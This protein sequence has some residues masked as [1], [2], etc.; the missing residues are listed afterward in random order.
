MGDAYI[1]DAVRTPRGKGR[2]S[3]S[4][5]TVRP[6][7]LLATALRALRDRNGLDTTQVDDVVAGCVTQTADQGG[8]IA[9]YAALTAGYDLD[10]AGLTLNRFCGSGLEAINH[11]GAMV[12][13]GYADLIVAGGVESMSRVKMGSDGGAVWDP[14]VQ[15]QIGSVPQGVSADLLAML[16]GITREQVD[17][18]ALRSQQRATAARE[19]GHFARSIV[20]VRDDNGHLLLDHDELIRPDT[21]AEGLAALKPA[22]EMLGKTFGMDELTRREYPQV[23]SIDHIHHAG[24]SSGIVDGAAA[25]LVGSR[26]KGRELGLT[27]RARIRGV[28]ISGEEPMLMLT[29]PIPSTRK[30]LKKASMSIS[31]VDLIEVNEAFAAVPLAFMQEYDLDPERVN[32]DGGAIAMGHPLGA[33]GAVLLSTVLGALERRDLTTGLVTL[34]IGGGMGIATIIERV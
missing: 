3:G 22:F 13:S 20:P 24:N 17:A 10:C 5:Y 9:R 31:D 33:T 30:A 4:L 8:C 16:F 15:W 21:T 29:G 28:G 14:A 11:A 25:V 2:S 7:E 19:A 1:Y 27:P 34:C 26:E 23:E 6:V 12:A 18:F 32:V